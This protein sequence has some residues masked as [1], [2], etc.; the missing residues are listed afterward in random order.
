MGFGQRC[1]LLWYFPLGTRFWSLDQID[2]CTL[3][4]VG[5]KPG[6]DAFESHFLHVAVW[7][8]DLRVCN[9]RGY[10]AGIQDEGT[11]LYFPAGAMTLTEE[12][13]HAS[14]I[15]ELAR[16]VDAALLSQIE[17]HLYS[18]RY[19]TAVREAAICVELA[20]RHATNSTLHGMGL[21]D[22]WFGNR[23]V[24]V[25]PNPANSHRLGLRAVWCAAVATS[26]EC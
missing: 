19:D 12:G 11:Y 13:A 4:I 8:D 18:R 7:D 10:V 23:G 2:Q 20:M 6:T 14:L 17:D 25:P 26:F 22:H 21:V 9:R 5:R 1:R 3:F 24:L 15:R 16:D